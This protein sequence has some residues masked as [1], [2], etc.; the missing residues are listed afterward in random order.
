M[1]NRIWGW[2]FGAGIVRTPSNFGLM[3]DRPGNREL[4]EYLAGRFRASGYSVKGLIREIVLSETYLASSAGAEAGMAK[5]PDNRLFWRMSRKR[6][7]AEAIR[8]SI[9]A[10]S[11]EL[12]GKAGGE[13]ADLA[14]GNLRRTVYVRVGRYQQNETLALFD[15]PSTSIHVEQR[16]VTNVPLQKLFFLNSSFLRSRA[17]A[18]ALRVECMGE[19]DAERLGVIYGLLFQRAPSNKERDAGMAFLQK[20]DW[21]QYA[22]VLLSSNEFLYVD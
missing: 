21:A 12:D 16:G 4:L 18:L 20:A 5:D 7:D 3:G 10:V 2:L 8:D 15:F 19:T 11:G 6:L 9:L 13:S 22:Q 17:E 1:V 14:D